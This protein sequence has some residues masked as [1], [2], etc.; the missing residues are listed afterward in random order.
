MG[1]LFQNDKLRHETPVDYITREFTHDSGTSASTV[2][3]A[4][5]VGST[6]YAANPQP[7]SRKRQ[8]LRL[9]RRDPVQEQRARR[10]RI[11]GHG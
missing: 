8:I 10:L 1:W 7:R 9:L 2:I 6:I 3:G 11:Q 5:A 4:A